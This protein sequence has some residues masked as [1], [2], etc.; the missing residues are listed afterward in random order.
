[1]IRVMKEKS[2]PESSILEEFEVKKY[3]RQKWLGNMT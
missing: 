1:M 3:I 2:D